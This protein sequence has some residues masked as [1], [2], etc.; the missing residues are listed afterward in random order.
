[1]RQGVAAIFT[2][3]VLCLPSWAEATWEPLGGQEI[4]LA[5][6]G[7]GL[8][9]DNATKHFYASGRTLYHSGRDSWG[10]WRVE[11]DE[12]CSQ[13]PPAD[14]WACYRLA[15]NANSTA[16]KFIGDSRDETI[17]TYSD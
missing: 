10:Y 9:Y 15:R 17:G 12:Y 4:E 14:G 7:R 16:L 6:K 2:S 5:L 13:W 8:I 11:G 1:M 3:F